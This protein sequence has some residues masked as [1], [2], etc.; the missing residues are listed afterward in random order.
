MCLSQSQSYLYVKCKISATI[1][2]P[3]RI[4]VIQLIRIANELTDM[5]CVRF[6]YNN[7]EQILNFSF[8]T[9][10]KDIRI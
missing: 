1:Q 9:N 6:G 8:H 4:Y 3:S 7:F 10:T 2:R 5:E